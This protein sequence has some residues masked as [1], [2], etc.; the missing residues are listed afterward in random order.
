MGITEHHRK[1]GYQQ[2]SHRQQ[3]AQ[4]YSCRERSTEILSDSSQSF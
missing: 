2:D 1:G 3:H 4:T